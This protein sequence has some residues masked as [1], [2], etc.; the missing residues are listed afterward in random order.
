[1]NQKGKKI[2]CIAQVSPDLM[3]ARGIEKVVYLWD[4]KSKT[5]IFV[6][7]LEGHTSQIVNICDYLIDSKTM[8]TASLK[9]RTIQ[10]L[11]NLMLIQ[12]GLDP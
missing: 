12:T 9:T 8:I 11:Q 1:M 3:A 7:G 2:D 4:I 6:A 5:K 10:N